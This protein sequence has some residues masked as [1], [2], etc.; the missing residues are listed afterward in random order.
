[1]TFSR[2][3]LGFKLDENEERLPWDGTEIGAP[4]ADKASAG[5]ANAAGQV[6]LYV[7]DEEKTAVSEVRPALGFCVSSSKSDI[8]ACLSRLRPH[9]GTARAESV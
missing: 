9:K 6:V 2:A 4:P 1:M 7:A 8:E 5:R 3:R